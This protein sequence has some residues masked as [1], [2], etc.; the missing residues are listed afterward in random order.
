MKVR[1]VFPV[2][3]WN[4]GVLE[5]SRNEYAKLVG[6]EHEV[7][8]VDI[9]KGPPS[10]E[11]KY[12]EALAAPGVIERICE[13]E[14]DGC[15]AVVINCFTGPGVL[16]GREVVKIPVISPGEIS[17]HLATLLGHC[18]SV[19]SVLENVVPMINDVACLCG[20]ND[21]L[22]SVRSIDIP[23]LELHCDGNRTEEA[24]IN[25]AIKAINEDHA[26]CL[27]LGCTGMVGMAEAVYRGLIDKGYE[28]PVIDPLSAALKTARV[29]T[30]MNLTYS[31]IIYPY[32]LPKP[33]ASTQQ[34]E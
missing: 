33:I 6:L 2:A 32:P 14:H 29:L 16:P 30:E 31:K 3:G 11:S 21:R 34:D 25:E 26:D 24:L 1:V 22:A 12:D 23:V 27:V 20:L 13:A 15:D 8:V 28:V 9:K 19:L 5:Q 10:I 7:T 18:F 17:M 4:T